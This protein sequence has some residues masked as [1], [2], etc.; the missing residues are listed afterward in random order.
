M[1]T[2]L[3]RM[4]TDSWETPTHDVTRPFDHVVLQDYMTN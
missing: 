2:K 4:V 1:A 3:G